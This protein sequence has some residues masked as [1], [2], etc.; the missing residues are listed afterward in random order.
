MAYDAIGSLL[1]GLVLMTFAFFLA[2]ENKDLLIGEAMSKRDYTAI[3]DIV[4]KIPEV[5]KIISIRTMHLA[6]EDVI[7]AIEVSLVDDLNT[8]AIESII[9]NIES[10]VK[11]VIP[12]A[13]SSKIYVELER[14]K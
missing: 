9:D 4:S 6:P 12:Y 14:A 7:I 8:D 10:K 3:L 5:D 13:T 11:Q 2:R 1:I